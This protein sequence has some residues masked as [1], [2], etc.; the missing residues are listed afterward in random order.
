MGP[1]EFPIQLTSDL[2]LDYR[3]GGILKSYLHVLV[4]WPLINHRDNFLHSIYS[5]CNCYWFSKIKAHDISREA[6]KFTARYNPKINR[7][8]CIENCLCLEKYYCASPCGNFKFLH[9]SFSY[10]TAILF[11]FFR[12]PLG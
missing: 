6:L 8:L 10:V 3:T 12:K 11:L 1:T 7:V 9:C 2:H 5:V 4:V